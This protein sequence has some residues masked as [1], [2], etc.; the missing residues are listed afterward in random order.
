MEENKEKNTRYILILVALLL[1]TALSIYLFFTKKELDENSI[2]G[3]SEQAEE[4]LDQTEE[5]TSVGSEILMSIISPEGESFEKGQARMWEAQLDGIEAD[6]SFKATCHWQFYLNENNEE[7]LYEEMENSSIVEKEDPTLCG[8]T[9]TFI[10]SR[11]KL[12]VKLTAEI[13]NGYGEILEMLSAE[14]NYT[15]L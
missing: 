12:R 4:V 11:G 3:N 9:S 5:G 15:V 6:K 1:L 14:R 10:E 13:R 7:T 8:F 2:G